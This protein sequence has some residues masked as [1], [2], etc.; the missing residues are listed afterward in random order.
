[1]RY[2]FT[3]RK[4]K[5]KSMY[6]DLALERRRADTS[7]NG[8]EYTSSECDGG[9]WE[10]VRIFSDE[11]ARSIGRPCGNYDTLCTG[12]MDL[13]DEDE[14]A[15]ATEAVSR[16]LCE[17]IDGI[18]AFPERI[19]VVGLGNRSLTPDSVGP[20]AAATVK[21]TMHIKDFDEEAFESLGCS[22]IAVLSP[23]VSAETG[24]EAAEIVR[25]ISRRIIPDVIIAIDAIATRST[26][27]LG[28]TIQISDTGLF[29]GSGIGNYRS[30]LTE[31]TI[32]FPIISVG[33][34]TVIDSR[35]FGS[36]NESDG[37]C[38]EGAMLVSPKEID[39]IVETASKIIGCAINQAFG[40]SSYC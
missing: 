11:G 6:T 1:M 12:R 38:A 34:P 20:K 31:D 9:I 25:G 8:V 3:E 5:D 15:D 36:D 29:P 32:G 23:G 10:C 26:E 2:Y 37:I 33:V 7:L 28:R 14:I 4:E 13:L 17:I 16:K 18:G 40:I 21:P 19:L 39:E 35:V 27:R 30:A 22:E 24:M